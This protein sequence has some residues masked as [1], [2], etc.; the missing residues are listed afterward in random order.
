MVDYVDLSGNLCNMVDGCSPPQN[1]V[2]AYELLEKNFN[3]HYTTNRAPFPMFF[4][5][6]W[7][8]HYPY[9]LN[10]MQ[11]KCYTIDDICK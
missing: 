2:E 6:T 11:V 3:I 4:H 5:A 1:E 8:A 10:G 7:F 9:T